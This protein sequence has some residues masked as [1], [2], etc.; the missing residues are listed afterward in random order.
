MGPLIEMDESWEDYDQEEERRREEMFPVIESPSVKAQIT[1]WDTSVSKRK[2]TPQIEW[3]LTIVEDAKYN[4]KTLIH[5][6]P[7]V[8]RGKYVLKAFLEAARAGRSGKGVDP[9]AVMGKF[10]T[11]SLSVGATDDGRKFTSIDAVSAA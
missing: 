3:T 7:T 11:L 8:G 10:V 4:G 5:R 6:T 2:G 9:E 1:G